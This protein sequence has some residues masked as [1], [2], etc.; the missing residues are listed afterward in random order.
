MLD[1]TIPWKPMTAEIR[2]F[3]KNFHEND[4]SKEKIC[5]PK[6]S[7]HSDHKMK[8]AH[9]NFPFASLMPLPMQASTGLHSLFRQKSHT[10]KETA[11]AKTFCPRAG[12]SYSE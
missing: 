4:T 10:I 2:S 5:L 1:V 8:L 9:C 3:G 7:F 6:S 12:A 11:G